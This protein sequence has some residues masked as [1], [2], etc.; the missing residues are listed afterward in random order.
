MSTY[1]TL[2]FLHFGNQWAELLHANLAHL[3]RNSLL[4][5]ALIHF[6]CVVEFLGNKHDNERGVARDYLADWNWSISDQLGAR[7]QDLHARVAHLGRLRQTVATAGDFN[8]NSWLTNEAPT[9]LRGFRQFLVELRGA[10]PERY[11]LIVAPRPG[12]DLD[13]AAF[14]DAV[15]SR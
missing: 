8:W 7:V 6:R 3:T 1:E 5:A 13:L 9:V 4:D 10:S 2:L 15:L 11:E 14:L 12:S